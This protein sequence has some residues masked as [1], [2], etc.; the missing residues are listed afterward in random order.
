MITPS[1]PAV[2]LTAAALLTSGA[3]SATAA[4][5][6][7]PHGE[8]V[9]EAA[10]LRC[11]GV[12][13]LI[14]GDD[15]ANAEV[16][17]E[18]RKAGAGAWRKG[19]SLFRVERRPKGY[20][21]QGGAQR[22]PSLVV[23][24]PGGELFAGSAVLLEPDT[25]YEIRLTLHDP[26]GGSAERTLKGHTIGEPKAPSDAPVR[27]VA[28]GSGGGT[29]TAADPFKGLKAAQD[30]A[31]P[32]DRFLLHAGTYAIGTW[33]I[34]R[35]GEPGKPIIWSGA[36]DGEAIID[37][38]RPDDKLEGTAIFADKAH[39]VW[40]E[41]L[42]VRS[43]FNMLRAHDADRLV[44]RRCHL[45]HFICGVVA[46]GNDPARQNG[47]F[48]SDN[49]FEGVMP[50]PVTDE[51]Y[52]NLPE[53]RAIWV[54]GSG[55]E[56]CYN[57]VRHTKDGID[58]GDGPRCDNT[59][60]HNNEVS[61][62][63]DDGTEMDGSE[64]NNRCFE[65]RYTNVL[66]GISFQPIY[67]GPAYAFRN[68][69]YNMRGE[70]IKW[71]NAPDGALA[72]HNTFV[73]FGVP[74][75]LATEDSPVHCMTRNN[76]FVGTSGRAYS[77]DPKM[78]RCDFDYDG[79]AGASGD[80]FLKWNNVRYATADEARAKAPVYH[81]VVVVDPA[82]LFASGITA[83]LNN[84]TVFDPATIDLRLKAGSAA[85]DAGEVLPGFNDGFAG[86]APDLGAYEFGSSLPVYGIRPDHP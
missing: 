19:P 27:H 53:S 3:A 22:A 26:D 9:M 30:A 81:H 12:Y 1:L 37:G 69:V 6:A 76:L 10:T 83:P 57:R 16:D 52:R 56:F 38:G 66:V 74:A 2:L 62:C 65:N 64:R 7:K 13:W 72:I 78:I 67:G 41:H 29:G 75:Y 85:I 8:P 86:K 35:N 39:D 54:T 20:L 58:V 28:P 79:F 18:V 31:R 71:H 55:H 70:P 15:N 50:W 4:D 44:L 33:T 82:T 40:F 63:F 21:D 47:F 36:G 23:I 14:D 43:A 25:A 49:L 32:G 34:T 11:L 5:A 73:R 84:S 60:I 24:P 48:I 42:T 59:D 51:Q 77:L 61:E 17:M 68:A 46:T 80:I 45:H